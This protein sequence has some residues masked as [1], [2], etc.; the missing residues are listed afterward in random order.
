MFK[1]FDHC[2]ACRFGLKGKIDATVEVKVSVCTYVLSS[3]CLFFC[4]FLSVC[5]LSC[6]IVCLFVCV[7]SVCLIVF[8]CMLMAIG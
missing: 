2:C 7:S 1:N 6:L 5:L 3:A 8:T 4:P